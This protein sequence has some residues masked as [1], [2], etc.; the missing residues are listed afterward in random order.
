MSLHKHP[1]NICNN[2][3]TVRYNR[4]EHHCQHWN[5][6]YCRAC[7]VRYCK[8]CNQE[9]PDFSINVLPNFPVNPYNPWGSTITCRG[10]S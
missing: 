5:T 1:V 9:W 2:S 10:H 8:D 3:L 6:G 7:R 4:H